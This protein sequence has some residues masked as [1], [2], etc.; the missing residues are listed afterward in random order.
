[1][2]GLHKAARLRWNS[3]PLNKHHEELGIGHAGCV[4]AVNSEMV[5]FWGTIASL[6]SLLNRN[7]DR[8]LRRD[9]SADW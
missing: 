4:H 7:E 2:R 3:D 8:A 5:P 9:S 1:M 6:A